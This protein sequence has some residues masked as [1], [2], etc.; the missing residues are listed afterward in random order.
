MLIQLQVSKHLNGKVSMQYRFYI[1]K[2]EVAA[3]IV[4]E[5]VSAMLYASVYRDALIEQSGANNLFFYA[6]EPD[7]PRGFVYGKRE[8]YPG[9]K[10]G[11]VIEGGFTYFPDNTVEKG[12][13]FEK[14]LADPKLRF[15]QEVYLLGAINI[16]GDVRGYCE[17][18]RNIHSIFKPRAFRPD[19]KFEIFLKIPAEMSPYPEIP[20]W[21]KEVKESTWLAMQG[22]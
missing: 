22:K 1:G 18:C 12:K 17:H 10:F 9:L 20:E 19:R 21:F 13:M 2:G 11:A 3:K 16:T 4:S 8:D 15:D 6:N 7:R 5:M 14:L